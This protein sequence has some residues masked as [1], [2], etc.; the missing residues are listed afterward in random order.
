MN[1]MEI[2]RSQS[3]YQS[4]IILTEPTSAMR[5]FRERQLLAESVSQTWLQLAISYGGELSRL[6]SNYA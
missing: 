1:D 3:P 5:R 6:P 4:A 2:I